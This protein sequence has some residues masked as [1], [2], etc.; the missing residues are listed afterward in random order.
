MCIRDSINGMVFK[1]GTSL[2]KCYQ[3][4]E[5][6]SEDIDISYAASDGVPGESRK[7]QLKKSIVSAMDVPVSYTHLDVYKRQQLAKAFSILSKQ[8]QEVLV[9][10]FFFGYTDRKIGEKYGRSRTTVNY[11]KLAALKQLR[12]ELKRLEHE[13]RKENTL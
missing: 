6:F 9:L 3:I 4:L 1:G 5:R 7:R 8:R 11:W 10:Y 13:K 12:K 2:T